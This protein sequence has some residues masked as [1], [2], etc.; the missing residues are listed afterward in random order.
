MKQSVRMLLALVGCSWCSYAQWIDYRASGIPR[1]PDGKPNLTVPA[2]RAPDGRPDLSGLWLVE[3]S[4]YSE[5][6]SLFPDFQAV[7]ALTVP[8][9]DLSAVSKYAINIL[10]DFKPDEV[11]MRPE[12]IAR[13]R[14]SRAKGGTANPTTRCLPGG[15]P[16]IYLFPIP[17]KFIQTQGLIAVLHEAGFNFRQIYTDG[18]KP[19]ADP[20]S[21]WYGYSTGQWDHD[22]LV[23]ES[24]GFNDKSWLDAFGHPHSDALHLTERYQRRDF[25][26]LDVEVTVDDPKIYTKPFTIKY[27]ERLVPDSDILEY[28]CEE[29]EKDQQHLSKQ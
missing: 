29:N 9:D 23:V 13:F 19:P 24:T 8:G 1:M 6:K 11:P 4:P 28:V 3:P 17:A 12:A 2:P 26:H 18:R 27:T 25:G 20:Q 14:A 22:T 21:L 10:A 16:F 7:E 5:L 15:L